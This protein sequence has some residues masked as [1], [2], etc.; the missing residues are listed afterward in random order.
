[1]IYRGRLSSFVTQVFFKPAKSRKILFFN[2]F[3]FV[4]GQTYF[5]FEYI[6]NKIL[7][8]L[9]LLNEVGTVEKNIE[10]FAIEVKVQRQQYSELMLD[11]C[12]LAK[13]HSNKRT[14]ASKKS[15]RAL[16]NNNSSLSEAY[17]SNSSSPDL[18]DSSTSSPSK[19]KMKTALHSYM[20]IP[21]TCGLKSK[22][23][24]V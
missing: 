18:L 3:V 10:K 6:D 22:R 16:R 1:M 9:T 4:N 12:V 24:L 5:N 14:L 21:F 7:S 15:P 8:Y 17:R 13:N 2:R 20:Y 23:S 11:L 19:S